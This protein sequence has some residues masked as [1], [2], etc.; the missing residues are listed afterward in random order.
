M[1]VVLI[2]S[3]NVA[4]QLGLALKDKNV[5]VKQ[6]YSNNIIHAEKL[7]KK[8]NVSY[9]SNISDIY[10]KADIY[11]YALKDSVLRSVLK[12]INIPDG[13]HVHTGGSI[14]MNVF[15]GFASK[16]GVFYPL[17]TFSINK[18]VDFSNI[19]ICI[20]AVS[21]EVQKKLVELA[22]LISQK[23]YII[24]SEKRKSLHLSAVFASNFTNYLYDAAYKI[25]QDSGIDFEIIQP[26]ILETAEKIKTMTPF[27][28]QTGPAM[29]MDKKTISAHLSMLNKKRD[30]KKLY[31]L[32]T[33][34][35][36]KRHNPNN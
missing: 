29:R 6:V 9:I 24:N 35:I 17:Q 14:S 15:K 28:A 2:G 31:K 33:D 30:L 34:D 3:G 20:E 10:R 13:I 25:L 22:G 27:D 19:P 23:T 21:M 4:T 36:N 18:P 12:K 8:L 16:F 1:E 5:T 32:L 7:G 26:L 11:I